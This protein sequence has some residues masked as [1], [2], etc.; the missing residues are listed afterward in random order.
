MRGRQKFQRGSIF[1][2]SQ[3]GLSYKVLS[4][5]SR[6]G[7]KYMAIYSEAIKVLREVYTLGGDVCVAKQ[8]R[9]H[10]SYSKGLSI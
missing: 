6:E 8:S 1:L 9:R 4:S 2:S 7:S 5:P 3:S 10:T